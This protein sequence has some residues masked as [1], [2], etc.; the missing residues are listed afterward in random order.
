MK[1]NLDN[2]AKGGQISGSLTMIL[3]EKQESLKKR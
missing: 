3:R 2:S 1:E